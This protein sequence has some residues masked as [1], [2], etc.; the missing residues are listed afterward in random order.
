VST[1]TGDATEVMASVDVQEPVGETT[2]VV[3]VLSGGKARSFALADPSQLTAVRMRPFASFLHR[4]GRRRGLAVWTVRYRY[5]GWNGAERSPV[6][7]VQWALEEVRRRHGDVPVVVVGHSMGGRTALAVGGDR[8]VRGICALA[9]WTE[10]TD[11]VAQLAGKTVLIAHGSFD[12]VTSPSGSYSYARRAAQVAARVG[13]IVVRGD[14][15]AMLVRWRTWHRLAA[16]FTLGVLEI[17]PLPRGIARAFSRS[18]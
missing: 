13:Y 11:P 10:P 7:D 1:T 5:R 12:V 18:V 8:S 17:A 6:A 3:I 16:G 9:P 2:A 4:R 15:H 14:L